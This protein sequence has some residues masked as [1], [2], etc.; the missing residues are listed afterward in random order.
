MVRDDL[1]KD[2]ATEKVGRMGEP[3]AR[4]GEKG[5]SCGPQEV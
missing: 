2:V 5:G 4:Q 1:C 3:P